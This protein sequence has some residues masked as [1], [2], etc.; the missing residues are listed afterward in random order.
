MAH[1]DDK[2]IYVRRNSLR[3]RGFDYST[4]RIYYVTIVVEGRRNLF[5]DHR[6]AL[7][8]IDC[9]LRLRQQM[10]FRLYIYCLMPDHI[11]ALIGSGESGKSLG[12]ICGTFKSI[13]TRAY[14]QWYEG[15]LWQRQFFD[16]V[17]RNEEEFYEK[18]EYV[19]LNPV[20]RGL[21]ERP[22][23]WPYTGKVD[24]LL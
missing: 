22:D 16:R 21:V 9:L 10:R 12:E 1:I 6:L 23:R 8:I 20:R 17:I 15:K 7:S 11:H 4:K 24:D 19:R 13:S 5:L 14:W 3:L 2:K 18:L